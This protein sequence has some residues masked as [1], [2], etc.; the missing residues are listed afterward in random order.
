MGSTP[1]GST[2]EKQIIGLKRYEVGSIPTK[3]AL[4]RLAAVNRTLKFENLRSFYITHW[5]MVLRYSPG[6]EYHKKNVGEALEGSPKSGSGN[7]T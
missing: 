5:V 3:S 2:Y 7:L 1:T 6:G 4:I